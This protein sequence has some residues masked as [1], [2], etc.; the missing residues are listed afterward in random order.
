MKNLIKKMGRRF[1]KKGLNHKSIRILSSIFYRKMSIGQFKGLYEY[2]RENDLIIKLFNDEP[3]YGRKACRNEFELENETGFCR[4][5]S[6][7]VYVSKLENVVITG[8]SDVIKKDNY[9]LFDRFIYDPN[10]F[11]RYNPKWIL[12]TNRC[13]GLYFEYNKKEN[14]KKGIYLVKMWSENWTH[15]L[16]ETISRLQFL[17]EFSQYDNYPILLDEHLFRDQRNIDVIKIFNKKNHP[18]IKIKSD[19]M[20]SVDELI[21]PSQFSWFLFDKKKT[22]QGMGWTIT[23]QYLCYVRD[24]FRDYFKSYYIDQHRAKNNIYLSRGNNNRLLNEDFVVEFLKSND[25]K[26]V[27]TAKMTLEEEVECFS[28]ASTVVCMMG[29][30]LANMIFCDPNTKIFEFCPLKL[31]HDSFAMIADALGMNNYYRINCDI[32]Q[33]G[34]QIAETRISVPGEKLEKIVKLSKKG[35]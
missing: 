3:H 34:E 13:E 11:G 35:D 7:K 28:N 12:D 27:N 17:D 30:G 8:W 5:T 32:V 14:I 1:L 9:L 18:I 15:F 20:Y 31:Q 6:Y 23:P 2:C 29:S 24:T 33:D 10:D 22:E 4:V 21:Y 19:T 26:I 16:V 25:F